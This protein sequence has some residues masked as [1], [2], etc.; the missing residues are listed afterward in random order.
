[1]SIIVIDYGLGNLTSVY[2]ALKFLGAKAKI[3]RSPQDLNKADKIVLP[4]VGAFKDAMRGLEKRNLVEAIK[5]AL[6]SGKAY[7]GICLGLHVL[8]EESQEGNV[9]GIGILK[10]SVKRLQEKDGVKVPHIGWNGIKFK[11]QDAK[12][13][14][15]DGIEEGSHFYFDHSYYAEPKDGNIVAATTDYGVNF[16]SMLHRDN[17]YAVQ[18]HPERSQGLGLKLLENFIK[19]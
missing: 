14:I 10:G 15:T 8:F 6:S 11:M 1:M 7:L 18:F 16:A 3:S 19:L 13:K 2:N 5:K 9:N 12:C 17:I 4:G